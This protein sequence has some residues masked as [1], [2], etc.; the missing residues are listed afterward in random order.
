MRLA[1]IASL[2]LAALVVG[3]A[4]SCGAKTCTPQSCP[5][6]CCSA[7]GTCESGGENAA[8]GSS[9]NACVNCAATSQICGDKACVAFGTGGGMGGGGGATGGGGGTMDAGFTCT[10][11]PVE[12]SDQAIQTLDLKMNTAAGLITNAP[13]DGG[14][15]STI[16]AR[17]G[18]FTPTESYVYARFTDV[19]LEKLPISDLAALDSMDW[20][21]A[22][23]RFV[24]R[25][26][27]GD[28]GPGCAA[29]QVLPQGTTFESISAVPSGLLPEAD[30]FLSR[31]PSCDFV[32]DGSGL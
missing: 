29:G 14:V 7:D 20:D 24:I 5:T 3:S 13:F 25:V 9:G 32:A 30:D 4:A 2:V 6:G 17:G 31:A 15:K 1:L 27:S 19:G 10:L 16:D 26:N 28:S 12:C 23:R 11:T 22:F 8:C 21:I 18:G